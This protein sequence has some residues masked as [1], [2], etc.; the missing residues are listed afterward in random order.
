[1]NTEADKPC[2]GTGAF[3]PWE[4]ATLRVMIWLWAAEGWLSLLER[5]ANG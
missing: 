2:F 3:R 4:R 1:M 5:W